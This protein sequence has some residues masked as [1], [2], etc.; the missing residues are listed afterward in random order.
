MEAEAKGLVA[1][2]ARM[3]KEA[4]RMYP[5]AAASH[6]DSPEPMHIKPK[7]GRPRATRATV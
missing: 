1:E 2:A 6:T 7:R 4:E 3:K 5:N